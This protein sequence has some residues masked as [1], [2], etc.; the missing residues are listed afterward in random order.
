MSDED[1]HV[2]LMSVDQRLQSTSQSLELAVLSD[3]RTGLHSRQ[4][5]G[6]NTGDDSVAGRRSVAGHS[7]LQISEHRVLVATEIGHPEFCL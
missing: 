1:R 7:R 4:G 6:Q 2:A 3:G 5:D